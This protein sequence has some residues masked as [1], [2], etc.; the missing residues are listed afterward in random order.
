MGSQS[1]DSDV[2]ERLSLIHS[3]E[4]LVRRDEEKR[5]LAKQATHRKSQ[6]WERQSDGVCPG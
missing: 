5:I 1:K 6:R 2:T 4:V 3:C